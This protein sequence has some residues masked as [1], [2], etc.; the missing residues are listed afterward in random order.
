MHASA[1]FFVRAGTQ[2]IKSQWRGGCCY[3]LKK[4]RQNGEQATEIL[5]IM[6]RL[7]QQSLDIE[8]ERNILDFIDL[9]LEIETSNLEN[10]KKEHSAALCTNASGK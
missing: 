4:Q 9:E 8:D 6:N 3:W 10:L 2:N 5:E 7:K 1:H